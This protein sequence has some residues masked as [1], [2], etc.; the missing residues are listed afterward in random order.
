MGIESYL[1]AA[2]DA[3]RRRTS[4]DIQLW[5]HQSLQ[6]EHAEYNA[7]L[8]I[9]ATVLHVWSI[10]LLS[11]SHTHVSTSKE[12]GDAR[13]T[14][15][16]LATR[17]SGM[18]TGCLTLALPYLLCMEDPLVDCVSRILGFFFG[19]KI[20]D[21]AF[22]RATNPPVL[23]S[24]GQIAPVS[25]FLSRLK[26]IWLL[27]TETRYRAFDIAVRQTERGERYSILWTF[28]PGTIAP[29]LTI[30]FPTPEVKSLNALL[31]IQLG[32]ES[33][34]TFFHLICPNALFWQPFEA[35][36]L[37]SFWRTHWHAGAETFLRSLGYGPSKDLA[38]RLGMNLQVS[39][40][41]GVLAA[42]NL[43][44][45]WHGWATAA[46]AT[47]PWMVG[48][49]VW[50]LFVGMGVGVILESSVFRKWRDSLP[51]RIFVWVFFIFVSN[52]RILQCAPLLM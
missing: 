2:N 43:T 24:D 42:F 25:S 22:V 49:R 27:L 15:I 11:Y 29:L 13:A 44:G 45:I 6:S 1:N 20:L 41:M 21:L 40:A 10:V 17:Y 7:S 34:H 28:G 9:T 51:N 14:R 33:I 12:T 36:S 4:L 16:Q 30:P 18:V 50:A 5:C 31:V 37:T 35:S 46:L 23:V 32:L 52:S 38:E 39:R 3:I 19:C 47:R 26:Y 8:I 48:F